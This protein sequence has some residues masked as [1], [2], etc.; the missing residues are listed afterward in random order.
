MEI[1]RY[2]IP[3]LSVMLMTGCYEDFNPEIGTKP[4][5]CI[6]SLITAGEPIDVIVSHTWM[7][8]DEKS[9]KNHEVND[10]IVTVLCNER[11]VGADYIPQEGDK[12][13]I[14]AESP[15][16]GNAMAEVVV[17]YATPI[18]KVNFTPIVTNIWKG[19]ADSFHY[20]MLADITFNLNIEMNV[21]DP[22]G[23]DNYYQFGY[24][25]FSQSGDDDIYGELNAS[26]PP[27]LSI[28]TFEY[29]AEPIFKE[30]IGVFETVMGNG[31]DT[32]F[33]FFTD[34]Q[35][36][37]K[38]YTLHLNFTNNTYSVNNPTYDDSL[39]ECGM[40][41]YLTTVSESYYNWAV[42]QWNFDEGIIGDLSEIGLAESKWGYSNVSTGAGIVAA[43]SSSKFTIDLKEFLKTTLNNK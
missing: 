25:W 28:G 17:P 26:R 39:L 21:N 22:A 15:T 3:A 42:Y 33:V 29:N 38:T 19:D 4:V 40:T 11:I 12:V 23:T 5:L 43:Q 16:Y 6:N 32:D 7:F 24:N 30:H 2:I 35:F 9:E 14:V 36:P 10:A 8:N 34:R 41:L 27:S 37:G 31:E 1:L 20:E 18:G 13:K